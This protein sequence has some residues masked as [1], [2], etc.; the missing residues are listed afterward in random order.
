[1]PR[2]NCTAVCQL[3]FLAM[4]IQNIKK[5]L[6]QAVITPFA[7]IS[8]IFILCQMNTYTDVCK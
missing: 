3:P 4:L 7:F 6:I 5:G 1:M 8:K 2:H